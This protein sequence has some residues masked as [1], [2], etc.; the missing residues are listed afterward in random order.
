ML[1]RNK[2]EYARTSI[3]SES[4]ISYHQADS[5][6]LLCEIDLSKLLPA[7]KERDRFDKNWNGFLESDQCNK[8]IFE[9][10]GDRLKYQSE[11]LIPSKSNNRIPLLLV[12]GNPASHSVKAGMFFALEKGKKEHRFWKGVLENAGVLKLNQSNN[13]ASV[14]EVNESRKK[15]FLDLNYDSSF[16]I[17]LCVFISMP[18]APSKNYSGVA[19]IHKL[20]GA[21]AM[22][23]L[24]KEE[25]K[26]VLK[27]AREFLSPDGAVVTFQKNAWNGLRS[28]NDPKYDKKLARTGEL[29]GTLIGDSKIPLF[30]VPPTRLVGPCR[31]V[32]RQHLT[33]KYPDR[34][35]GKIR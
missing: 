13:N 21:K 12:L 11:H 22:R 26:R 28:E 16:R 25:R 27:C 9:Q 35:Q 10:K 2:P 20:I 34:L 6:R 19:G 1:N 30:C 14:E 3:M 29:K 18:S 17:G 15:Q 4:I 23:E 5:I 33:E 32:L 24:E 7:P 31:E 8:E